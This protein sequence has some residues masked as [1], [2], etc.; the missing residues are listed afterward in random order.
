MIIRKLTIQD[1][2]SFISF[3]AEGLENTPEAFG[4]SLK[5]F[6]QKSLE[7]IKSTFPNSNTNFL[8]GMFDEQKLVGVV[9]FFQN[10]SEKM[11]HKAGIWGMF[12]TPS[13]RKRGI[14]R[15]LM[16]FAIEKGKEI[17]EVKQ[18][19]LGVVSTNIAAK[20]LYKSLGFVSYGTEPRAICVDGTYYDEDHMV[21]MIS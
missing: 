20:E 1:V 17:V 2:E 14:A 11:K 4:E 16:E 6:N 7:S 12:V 18:I 15:K 8:V 19:S 21:M 10:R 5:E 3:R 9:G 13:F